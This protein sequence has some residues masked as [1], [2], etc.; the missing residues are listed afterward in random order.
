MKLHAFVAMPSGRKSG[1][2]GTAHIGEVK[3]RT[4]QVSWI[5]TRAPG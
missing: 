4:G 5:D 1:A 2:D 3:R